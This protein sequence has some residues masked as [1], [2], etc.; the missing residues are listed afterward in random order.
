ML[1]L[2]FLFLLP[3]AYKSLSFCTAPQNSFLPARLVAA[4]FKSILGQIN[5]LMCLSLPFNNSG[6]MRWNRRRHPLTRRRKQ[7]WVPA[8]ALPPPA[9]QLPQEVLGKSSGSS[10]AFTLGASRLFSQ[11]FFLWTGSG[12]WPSRT[13]ST[14]KPD[15]VQGRKGFNLETRPGAG[16]NGS[17]LETGPVPRQ[18]PS[19]FSWTG[20]V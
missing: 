13:G 10:A 5:F 14:W 9:V 16:R 12:N 11:P 1:S 15:R 2:F 3:S 18:T 20:P 7:T 4:R 17:D 8:E 6:V 19:D